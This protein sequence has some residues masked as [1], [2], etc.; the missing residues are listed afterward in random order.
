MQAFPFHVPPVADWALGFRIKLARLGISLQFA[1]QA[2]RSPSFISASD[3]ANEFRR[4]PAQARD[5]VGWNPGQTMNIHQ[6]LWEIDL[7]GWLQDRT[8]RSQ[9]FALRGIEAAA[10]P[11]PL[12]KPVGRSNKSRNANIGVFRGTRAE[13]E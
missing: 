3:C 10:K 8:D 6:D 7:R 1:K 2:P 9:Q 11:C 12:A 4:R 5:S 13:N